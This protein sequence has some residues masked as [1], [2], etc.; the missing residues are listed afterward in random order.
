MSFLALA[1]K[2]PLVTACLAIIAFLFA[3]VLVRSYQ[4]NTT[5]EQIQHQEAV[6]KTMG[7]AVMLQND[8]VEQAELKAK[9]AAA[10]GAAALREA[11]A[12]GKARLP[13]IETLAKAAASPGDLACTDAVKTVRDALAR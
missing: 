13:A 12:A 2:N 4:L 10:K 7:D 5:R 8:A 3:L 11:R 9:D 1:W 6:I